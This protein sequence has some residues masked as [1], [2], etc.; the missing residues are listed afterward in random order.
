MSLCPTLP[1]DAGGMNEGIFLY[2][3]GKDRENNVNGNENENFFS[4]KM[5]NE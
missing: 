4:R 1:A 5:K 3:E 2:F